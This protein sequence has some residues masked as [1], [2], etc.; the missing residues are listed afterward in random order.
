V[1]RVVGPSV[2]RA[3]T[4]ELDQEKIILNNILN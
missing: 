3:L 1:A 4:I 2:N